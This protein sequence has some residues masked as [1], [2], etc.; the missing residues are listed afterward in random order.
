MACRHLILNTRW[1]RVFLIVE[2]SFALS[3][4]KTHMNPTGGGSHRS[5]MQV[6]L[7]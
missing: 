5:S 7:C 1:D 4:I 6:P 2:P 3:E